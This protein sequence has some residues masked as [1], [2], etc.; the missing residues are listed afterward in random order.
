M[1]D[2][3]SKLEAIGTLLK[4][5]PEL[6][7]E[8]VIGQPVAVGVLRD[9]GRRIK[10]PSVF[11]F[12]G[13]KKPKAIA[14]V[15]PAGAGKTLSLRAFANEVDCPI[16]ELKYEDVATH[17][18]DEE[19]KRLSA[20][21]AQVEDLAEIHGHVILLIDEADVFFQRRFDQNTHNS[22]QKKT[23]FFLRWIDGDLEVSQS[24]FTIVVSSNAWDA[25]DPAI[26]RPG[27]FIKV[28]YKELSI[29]DV[30]K[31]IL[32]HMA[33]AERRVGRKLFGDF[34]ID[35]LKGL[36]VGLSGADVNM[37]LQKVLLKRANNHLDEVLRESDD[38]SGMELGVQSLIRIKELED[39]LVEYRNEIKV[40][41]KMV[42]FER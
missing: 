36:M 35:E 6:L 38:D 34:A 9:L 7:L 42:G 39:V 13:V 16:L 37:I 25:I 11:D 18:F 10:W 5:E 12:W 31:C 30:A 8:H 15:G 20:L 1:A 21:K 27:R 2:A 40:T 22:D 4:R 26:R 24:N 19:I 23:N 3:E 17:L 33:L 32:V 28:E 41:K 14:L 29:E